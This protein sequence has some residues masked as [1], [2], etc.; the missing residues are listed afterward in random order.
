MCI[1]KKRKDTESQLKHNFIHVCFL[2]PLYKRTVFL[3][4]LIWMWEKSPK[5]RHRAVIRASQAICCVD[6]ATKRRH[7]AVGVGVITNEM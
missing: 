5:G 3:V 6:T 4:L 7:L 2:F 1:R